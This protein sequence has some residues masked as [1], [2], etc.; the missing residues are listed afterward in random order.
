V[1]AVWADE[2]VLDD[3]VPDVKKMD[4]FLLSM[5]DNHFWSVGEIIGQAWRD[6]KAL[7]KQP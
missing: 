3:G 6:G 4:P 5:P 2:A 1:K 7:K